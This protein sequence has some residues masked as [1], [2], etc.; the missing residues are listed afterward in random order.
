MGRFDDRA[1]RPAR[2]PRDLLR[3]RLDK[4]R[5]VG[6]SGEKDE[7]AG[8]PR[9]EN[10]GAALRGPEASLTWIGHASFALRLGGR[11]TAIDPIWSERIQ[12]V[13]PRLV[14]PGVAFEA[15][16]L[17]ETVLVSHNHYDHLDLPT[18]K[19]IGPKARYVVPLGNAAVLREAGLTE[20]VEL[21]WWQTHREG[22]VEYT[23]V[24]ARHW[25]MRMP[26]N[27]NDMLWGGWVIR[28]PEGVAYHSGDTA[29]FDGFTEIGKRCGPI[30]WAM[31]PIGAYEPRWFMEPQHMN[32]DD[33]VAAFEALGARTFVAMHWGTFKLTDEPLHQPPVRTRALWAERSHDPA[34]LWIMDV[35]ETRRLSAET[36][37]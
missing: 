28:G 8:A 23:L 3:W 18:L 12:G 36:R 11:M 5:G 17:I 9:R 15:T 7:I 24:P 1:T 32:P 29:A 35:G 33:A 27:R 25:S 4:L 31:L 30:D 2:G 6:A 21:D 16:P 19:R 10:D 26:W 22:D 13:V 34:R 37:A 14:P 20:V